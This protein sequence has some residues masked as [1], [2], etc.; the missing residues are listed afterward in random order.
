MSA[1]KKTRKRT[2]VQRPQVIHDYYGK[3]LNST[4]AR[5]HIVELLVK[6]PA[7]NRAALVKAVVE[8]HSQAG[9][10]PGEVSP[11]NCVCNAL[12][13]LKS[14]GVVN[15]EVL[16]LWRPVGKPP[17]VVKH[18]DQAL[19]E[20]EIESPTPVHAP[21]AAKSVEVPEGLEIGA[22]EESLSILYNPNDQRL[23][24]LE[25][26]DRWECLISRSNSGDL[27]MFSRHP[28]TGL[29][30]RCSNAALM[31]NVLKASLPPTD[32]T[33]NSG[34]LYTSPDAVKHWYAN[35]EQLLGQFSSA[36]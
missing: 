9:G 7:W 30:I 15:N 14:V 29:V 10:L 23:A 20:M 33:S 31:E 32:G 16:G 36:R 1:P 19:L 4:L 21:V 22:G 3:P 6:R 13:G 26:R 28:V 34:W 18:D 35:F 25:G 5:S 11:V 24:E 12:S 27:P 8:A 2:R 17:T